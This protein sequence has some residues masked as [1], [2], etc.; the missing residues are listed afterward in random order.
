MCSKTTEWYVIYPLISNYKLK[1]KLLKLV[2]PTSIKARYILLSFKTNILLKQVKNRLYNVCVCVCVTTELTQDVVLLYKEFYTIKMDG[3]TFKKIILMYLLWIPYAKAIQKYIQIWTFY[4]NDL[5]VTTDEWQSRAR[6]DNPPFSV[7][8]ASL[9]VDNHFGVSQ[10]Q[11]PSKLPYVYIVCSIFSTK[12]LLNCTEW[13]NE[14]A[15]N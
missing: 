14:N 3:Y 12:Q 8:F 2:W 7:I 4:S 9:L 6:V 11:D 13:V 10:M 1:K 5:V 15:G